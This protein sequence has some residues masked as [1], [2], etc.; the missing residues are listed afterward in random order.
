MTDFEKI[1]SHEKIL[2]FEIFGR[3]RGVIQKWISD[4]ESASRDHIQLIDTY[5]IAATFSGA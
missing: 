3:F 2:Y 5:W 4:S 1:P